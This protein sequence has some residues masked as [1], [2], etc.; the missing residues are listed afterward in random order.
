MRIPRFT[1]VSAAASAVVITLAA[2]GGDGSDAQPT[3]TPTSSPDYRT[4]PSV[5]GPGL[6][7]LLDL[8]QGR[9]SIVSAG[10]SDLALGPSA[11]VDFFDGGHRVRVDEHPDLLDELDEYR[12]SLEGRNAGREVWAHAELPDA[13][14][15]L[16]RA[17][18]VDLITALYLPTLS[19]WDDDGCDDAL[20]T[21]REDFVTASSPQP[22]W[23][24]GGDGTEIWDYPTERLPHMPACVAEI[25]DGDFDPSSTRLRFRRSLDRLTLEVLHDSGHYQD[26]R[27]ERLLSVASTGDEP[28]GPRPE[29]PGTSIFDQASVFVLAV[30]HCGEL[31]WAYSNFM[32]GNSYTSPDDPSYVEPGPF[33]SNYLCADEVPDR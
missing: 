7:E 4:V 20:A 13:D 12:A 15:T 31:P 28:S 14:P 22:S 10:T 18:V 16:H 5:A 11:T 24:A 25:Y 6:F 19:L 9:A 29:E 27:F 17:T 32:A 30:N 23:E 21:A 33:T 8:D 2:C 1:G 3:D 26:D